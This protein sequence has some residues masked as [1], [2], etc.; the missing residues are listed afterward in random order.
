MALEMSMPLGD[1]SLL[2]SSQV[3]QTVQRMTVPQ[4]NSGQ[5]DVSLKLEEMSKH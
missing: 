3:H 1:G 4:G 5:G 2:F